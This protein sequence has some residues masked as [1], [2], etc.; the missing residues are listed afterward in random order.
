[1][2]RRIPIAVLAVVSLAVSLGPGP[3]AASAPVAE[4]VPAGMHALTWHYPLVVGGGKVTTGTKVVTSP[5]VIAEVRSLINALP[6]SAPHVIC[7]AYVMLPYS[8]AFS[9]RV[10]SP[11]V[12]R[13]VFQLGGCPFAQVYQHGVKMSPTLG[14]P[15]LRSTYARIQ[16]LISP[17]GVPL[18]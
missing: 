11:A 2:R 12:T 3:S 5:Q 9:V 15:H 6:V 16:K 13:V 7:P 17:Q 10:G 8:V 4:R 18:G 1:M 14:G